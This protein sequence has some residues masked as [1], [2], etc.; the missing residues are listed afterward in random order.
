MGF[1]GLGPAPGSAG[2]F[3]FPGV[4]SSLP[5]Q[6]VGSP[7]SPGT[8][9]GIVVAVLVLAGAILAGIYISGHPTSTAALFFIEVSEKPQPRWVL[10]PPTQIPSTGNFGNA[11]FEGFFPVLPV[12]SQCPGD[13]FNSFPSRFYF[14]PFCTLP[15]FPKSRL[16]LGCFRSAFQNFCSSQAPSG[17]IPGFGVI[18]WDFLS[19]LGFFL[20]FTPSPVFLHPRRSQPNPGLS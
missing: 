1:G 20:S 3:F 17:F 14:S 6:N 8:I 19:F 9:V 10:A 4:G 2:L 7:I 18:P 15:F 12:I 13:D 11:V 5:S 16:V